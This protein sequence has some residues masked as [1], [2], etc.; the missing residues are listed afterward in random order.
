MNLLIVWCSVNL[1]IFIIHIFSNWG[2]VHILRGSTIYIVLFCLPF[3]DFQKGE[4][5]QDMQKP[6][7]WEIK[8]FKNWA[9]S[10]YALTCVV[11]FANR[12]KGEIVVSSNSLLV[13]LTNLQNIQWLN[14]TIFSILERMQ[15]QD[16]WNCNI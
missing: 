3:V 12:Q 15:V 4:K 5:M 13:Y 1:S 7:N 14:F 11:C 9:K 10:I 16:D 6:I 2:G 8:F